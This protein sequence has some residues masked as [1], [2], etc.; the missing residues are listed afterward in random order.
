MAWTAQ[1][2]DPARILAPSGGPSTSAACH[3]STCARAGSSA[4]TERPAAPFSS[5]AYGPIS[6]S[7]IGRTL[8]PSR[9]GE[10]LVAETDAEHGHAASEHRLSDRFLLL[11]EPRVLGLVPDIHRAAHDDQRI[12]DGEIGD[13]LAAIQPHLL[14]EDAVRL[15][16]VPEKAGVPGRHV[17]EDQDL[18]AAFGRRRN[19]WRRLYLI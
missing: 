10:Q 11:T 1:R 12:V 16:Q 18:Q 5:I 19:P 8:P 17:L 2:R 4:S 3:R 6:G 14:G 13:R 15:H 9:I 7:A